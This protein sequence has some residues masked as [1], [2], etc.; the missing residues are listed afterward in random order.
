MTTRFGFEGGEPG[1]PPAAEK[2]RLAK[3]V[4]GRDV[5]LP[6]L[7]GRT[8]ADAPAGTPAQEPRVPQATRI[9]GSQSS[10]Q[11]NDPRKSAVTASPRK[12]TPAPPRPVK[13]P[14]PQTAA[15][16][17]RPGVAR[18]LGRRNTQGDIVPLT[19]TDVLLP[20]TPWLRPAVTVA[21][22]ALGSFLL[23]ASLLWLFGPKAVPTPPP[24]APMPVVAA[25][26]AALVP[27]SPPI[28]APV[29]PR[30][31]PSAPA[32]PAAVPMKSTKAKA[33][34]GP[35]TPMRRSRPADPDAPLPPTFF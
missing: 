27:A 25:P 1:G 8:G 6:S 28:A 22:A 13:P 11:L 10:P 24:K 34:G 33:L 15:K 16:S 18:F 29:P 30:A 4:F 9:A 19:Q 26:A 12:R 35:N 21:V 2:P 31:P 5:H 20:T 17:A 3:T 14:A 32:A 7:P 23:V